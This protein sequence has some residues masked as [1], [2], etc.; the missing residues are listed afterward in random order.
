ME[1]ILAKN[2]G[3][4][5]GVKRAF[6]MAVNEAE[7]NT[8]RVYTYGPLTHNAEVISYL[9]ERDIICDESL[10]YPVGSPVVIRAHGVKPSVVEDVKSKGY[11]LI[12]ATCPFVG[13]VHE[14][15][16]SAIEKGSRVLVI[17][18]SKHPEIVGIK[19][20]NEGK[21]EVI[22][23][24]LEAKK[25]SPNSLA[26]YIC[27]Q[28]TTYNEEKYEKVMAILKEKS[29]DIDFVLTICSATRKRQDEVRELSEIVDFTIVLGGKN[30]SNTKKLYDIICENGKKA[31][32]I[33]KKSEIDLE[34][35]KNYGRIGIVAGASTPKWSIDELVE[36]LQKN[37]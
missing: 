5:Y 32:H 37:I 34:K 16:S 25:W 18:D 11:K 8:E 31:V 1:I 35:I 7:G 10:D 21:I 2:A 28:Q 4:C 3:F 30:S 23:D 26:H 14:I 22:K 27:V 9:E 36:H 15:V 19:G 17:G 6:D 20:I 33:E 12:D 29:A 13:R 24:A